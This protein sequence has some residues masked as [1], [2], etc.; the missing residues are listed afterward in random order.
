MIGV[1]CRNTH[2]GAAESRIKLVCK[3]KHLCLCARRNNTAAE[4]NEGALSLIDASCCLDYADLFGRKGLVRRDGRLRGILKK[5]P[6]DIFWDI[7]QYRA[8]SAG[9]GQ[10]E[11]LS[12]SIRKSLYGTDKVI[13]LGNRQSDTGMSSS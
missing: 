2:K 8:G 7:Y 1:N 11:S 13:V 9:F 5:L 3:L 10:T 12:D 4:E 6:L